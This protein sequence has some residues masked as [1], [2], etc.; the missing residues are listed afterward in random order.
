MHPFIY[1]TIMDC[2]GGYIQVIML[3]LVVEVA[4]KQLKPIG[5]VHWP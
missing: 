1:L 5:Q 4:S 3:K 2:L